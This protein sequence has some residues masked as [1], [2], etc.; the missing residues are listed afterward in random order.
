MCAVCEAGRPVSAN[1]DGVGGKPP[2]LLLL[3]VG[4]PPADPRMGRHCSQQQ[5]K[6]ALRQPGDANIGIAGPVA[7]ARTRERASVGQPVRAVNVARIGAFSDQ[8]LASGY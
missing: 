4:A 5:H 2:R 6:Q 3:L 1:R 7:A 8:G